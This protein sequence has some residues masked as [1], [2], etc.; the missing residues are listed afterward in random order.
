MRVLVTGG[1]GY[2]GSHTVLELITAGH[3]PVIVD[4]FSNSSEGVVRR[5]EDISGQ[6]I[7]FYEQDFQDKPALSKVMRDES[8]EGVIHFA[9]YKAVAESVADPLKYYDNNVAGFVALL[10]AMQASRVQT[11][12][13][14]ST[15]AVYGNPPVDQVTEETPANPE[16]PYGWSKRMNEIILRDLCAAQPDCKGTALRY[17]NVVGAHQSGRLGERSR[18]RPQNLLPIIIDAVAGKLPPVTVFGTDY[19]T[20]DGTCLRDYIH[21]TDLAAA[22]VAAL[23]SASRA[24]KGFFETYNIGT[25][26]PTSVLELINIFEKVNGVKVPHALGE[27]RAGDPVAYYASAAKAGKALGWKAAKNIEDACRD[28]WQWHTKN[29]DGYK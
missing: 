20:P 17:F 10:E 19:P 26:S 27:R 4:N 16:S 12:I 24:E 1:A 11:L 5:L 13:F 29:P 15:A 21:V 9:A 8:V 25:G 7:P 14:S 28:S 22:H 2:I 3:Q 23:E 18:T 6:K